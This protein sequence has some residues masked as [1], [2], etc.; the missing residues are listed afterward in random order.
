MLSLVFAAAAL[1]V[2]PEAP[3]RPPYHAAVPRRPT[4]TSYFTA[5]ELAEQCGDP[6]PAKAAYCFAY[7]ASVHD[8]VRAYEQW[9]NLREFC[10]PADTSQSDLRRAFVAHVAA[11]PADGAGQA[12][13]VV[14][15]AFKQRYPCPVTPLATPA[16]K[17]PARPAVLRPAR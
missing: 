17:S 11:R 5:S 14:V 16:V 7:I 2:R 1:Q 10:A 4:K 13:S 12:A 6:S 8:T 9:L 3:A 15:V